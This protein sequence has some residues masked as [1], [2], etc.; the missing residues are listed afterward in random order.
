M[1]TGN[2]RRRCSKVGKGY[3]KLLCDGD[4][5]EY[6]TL[7]ADSELRLYSEELPDGVYE[8]ERLIER[9]TKKVWASVTENVHV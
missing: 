1:A 7:H 5:V 2:K 6:D 9:R 8:V 3:Y 4:Q